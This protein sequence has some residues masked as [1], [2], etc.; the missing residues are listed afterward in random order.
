MELHVP[1]DLLLE[2]RFSSGIAIEYCMHVCII[3][4]LL[5]GCGPRACSRMICNNV[6]VFARLDCFSRSETRICLIGPPAM[7]ARQ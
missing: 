3:T 1:L 7:T 2:G 6:K 5:S 4:N